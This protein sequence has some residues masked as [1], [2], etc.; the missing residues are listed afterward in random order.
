MIMEH[1]NHGVADRAYSYTYTRD[2]DEKLDQLDQAIIGRRQIMRV[3]RQHQE[4]DATPGKISRQV[5]RGILK[6]FR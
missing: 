1:T 4:A 6:E 3:E 2:H 5:N